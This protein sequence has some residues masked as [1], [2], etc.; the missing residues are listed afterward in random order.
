[1][2]GGN[3]SFLVSIDVFSLSLPA[4][5]IFLAHKNVSKHKRESHEYVNLFFRL[6]ILRRFSEAMSS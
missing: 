3:N 2:G 1:M 4:E 5:R 6:Q